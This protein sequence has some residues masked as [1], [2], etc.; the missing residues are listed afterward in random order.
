MTKKSIDELRKELGGCKVHPIV[1]QKGGVG[2]ST[3]TSDICYTLARK[4]F[5]VLAIDTDP[6]A[7]LSSLCN[8]D[9]ED[10]E[11]LG[12]QEENESDRLR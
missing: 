7:S 8:I 2:K 4:G 5:K 11:V 3:L 10:E 6:Q 9:I 12:L 1:I